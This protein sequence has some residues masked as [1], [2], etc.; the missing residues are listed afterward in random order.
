MRRQRSARRRTARLG[1]LVA[2]AWLRLK[3]YRIVARNWRCKLGELDVVCRRGQ[4]IVFVE[5]RTRSSRSAGSPEASV[6]GR[7]QAQ[8][9]RVARAF[10]AR[11]HADAEEV[12]FDVVAVGAGWP[13]VRHLVGAFTAVSPTS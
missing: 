5:V 1:E 13:P 9:A 4:M 10:L 12:R 7:K 8:V 3:G 2:T 11:R 6:D